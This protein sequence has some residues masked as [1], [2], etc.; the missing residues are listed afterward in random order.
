VLTRIA[1]LDQAACDA[2]VDEVLAHRSQWVRRIPSA[3]F[4]TLGAA[5]YLDDGAQYDE[6]AARMNPILR[7][8]F[9]A[10]YAALRAA[11]ERVTGERVRYCDAKALPGFHVWGVPGIPTAGDASLHFDL[12][13]ER[14]HWP[15]HASIDFTR[16]L[17][18]TLP[19]RLPRLGGGLSVWDT[20]HDRVQ[21]F[22]MRTGFLGT[23]DDIASLL[24][25]RREAYA[26]GEL[27]VHSGHLLHRI[28]PVA[29]V[30]SD[31][32]RMTLQGHALFVDGA[33]Q[34]YW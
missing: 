22:Y 4:Y 31:D 29:E 5:S 21:A 8:R 19:V 27:V 28:A 26:C 18:F 23:I 3:E 9:G 30:H 14:L 15:A 13:Y 12:Q 11:I 25:E 10:L 33:W 24:V 34:L 7:D 32:V 16:P 6:L 17:S 1:L 2:I 20:T